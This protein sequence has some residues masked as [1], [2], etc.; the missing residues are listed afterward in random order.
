M[1]RMHAVYVELFGTIL[2]LFLKYIA[3]VPVD[4]HDV[5]RIANRT[6]SLM[7][8][9]VLNKSYTVDSL[10]ATPSSYLESAAIVWCFWV[11]V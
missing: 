7:F 9:A 5:T 1:W 11:C 10:P 4:Q 3:R 8:G 2:S 6:V